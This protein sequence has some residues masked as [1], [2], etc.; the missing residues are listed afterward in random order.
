MLLENNLSVKLEIKK[1]Y[2]KGKKLDDIWVF[3]VEVEWARIPLTTNILVMMMMI[4]VMKIR[5]CMQRPSFT[6]VF[7]NL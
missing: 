1:N 7:N 6:S 4:H 3:A 5:F 2:F